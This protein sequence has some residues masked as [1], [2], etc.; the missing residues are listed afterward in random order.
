MKST[1]LIGEFSLVLNSKAIIAK[2]LVIEHIFAA[3]GKIQTAEVEG[4]LIVISPIFGREAL[5]S[6]IN[7]LQ[8]Q[9]F[10]YFDDFFEIE[11]TLPEW[12]RLN[13]EAA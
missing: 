10:I 8:A 5:D 13:V 6:L 7:Q 1:P 11:Q 3:L 12:C 4:G 2:R 9:G